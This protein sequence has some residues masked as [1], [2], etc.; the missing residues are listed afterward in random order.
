M[1]IRSGWTTEPEIFTYGD[2]MSIR[3]ALV[4][5]LERSGAVTGVLA[6]GGDGSTKAKPWNA[7]TLRDETST[8]GTRT[9]IID[10]GSTNITANGGGLNV[11]TA[12]TA[13]KGRLV[14]GLGYVSKVDGTVLTLVSHDPTA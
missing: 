3:Q 5:L 14:P 4:T 7:K 6:I 12:V 1:E 9:M 13:L 11:P 2:S 8:D 10:I